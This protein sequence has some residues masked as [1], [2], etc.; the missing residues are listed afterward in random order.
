MSERL[1][2]KQWIDF[3][4][5]TLATQGIEAVRVEWLAKELQVTKGSFYWHF[6]NRNALLEEMLYAWQAYAT[7]DIITN[8]ETRGGDATER[9]RNLFITV[10]E[11]DNRLDKEVRN[12]A[13]SNSKVKT[14]LNTI[15]KKRMAYL[16]TLFQESGFTSIQATARTRLVYHALIG[17]FTMDVPGKKP[18]KQSQQFEIVLDMLLR[19]PD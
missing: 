6:K 14:A 11:A 3:G 10:L 12:W 13:D 15:D 1:G 8:V 16:D 17:Q 9:I 7:N 4:L 2:K 19:K 18:D 5:K